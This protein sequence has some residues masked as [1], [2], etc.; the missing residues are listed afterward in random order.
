M[1]YISRISFLHK[2]RSD[3][4]KIHIWHLLIK[5]EKICRST[6]KI[7]C[8]CDI[9]FKRNDVLKISAE[10]PKIEYFDF[11]SNMRKFIQNSQN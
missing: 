8:L 7:S 6:P 5:L 10:M 4:V 1:D 9:P 2:M 3:L 11:S